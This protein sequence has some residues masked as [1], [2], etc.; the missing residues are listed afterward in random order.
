[1]RQEELPR[2]DEAYVRDFVGQ[3]IVGGD[4]IAS[5]RRFSAEDAPFDLR[6]PIPSWQAALEDGTHVYI[7]AETGELAAV[8]TQ[9]WRVFDF[10]WGLHIMDLES[11][12][13]TSHPI[14]ILFAALALA[15][16]ILGSILMFRRR[17][18]RART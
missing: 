16:T 10:M 14:L 3:R 11:R 17:K 7:H 4:A 1:M 13:D 12:E 8:R 6:R 5:I 15:G 18:A 9:F 2:I